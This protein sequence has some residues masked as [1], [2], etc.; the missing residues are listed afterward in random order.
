[1]FT[2]F[3]AIVMAMSLL[4]AGV[5]A[6]E[7]GPLAPGKPSGVGQPQDV[8]GTVLLVG[9]GLLAVAGFAFLIAATQHDK[10]TGLVIGGGSPQLG[11]SATTT[12]TTT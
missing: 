3:G 11:G 4:A 2:R 10:S 12:T 6:A 8:R 7:L 9:G 5:Q 1:M